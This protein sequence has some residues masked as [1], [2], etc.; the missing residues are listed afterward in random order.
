MSAS[1]D[2]S[3]EVSVDP[4]AP[5]TTVTAPADLAIASEPAAVSPAAPASTSELVAPVVAASASAQS[6]GPASYDGDAAAM[7][8]D[9]A[10]AALGRSASSTGPDPAHEPPAAS[11]PIAALLSQAVVE[12]VGTPAASTPGADVS[13]PQPT[14]VAPV[15]AR[16][17]R[18]TQGPPLTRAQ[19]LKQ[20][21][22][23]EPTDS[24]AWLALIADAEQKG[25]LERTREVYEGFFKVYPDAS[26]QWIAYADLELQHSHFA[27]VEAIFSRCLRQSTS[28][29]LWRF[30]I[31][32]AR[33]TNAIDPAD[34]E[35]AKAARTVVGKSFD[36]ALAHIGIDRDAGPIWR[37]YLAFL[38]EGVTA[39][40]WEE[41]QRM[42]ALRKTYQRAICIPLAEVEQI[43]TEYNYFEQ[44][45]NKMTVRRG[46]ASIYADR[47]Q[48]KKFLA[49][50][51]AAYSSARVAAKEMGLKLAACKTTAPLPQRVD[52]SSATDRALVKG[53]RAY[54]A[55]EESNP[56]QL[57][58]QAA[59]QHRIGFAYRKATAELRFYPEVWFLASDNARKAGKADDA[60]ALLKSG[61]TANPLRCVDD[62]RIIADRPACSSTTP[63]PSSSRARASLTTA[64]ASTASSS[65][66][67]TPS[68]T[69]A[70][71]AWRRRSPRPSS[72]CPITRRHRTGTCRRA[73]MR[74]WPTG[75]RNRRGPSRWRPCA[76]G[77]RTSTRASSTRCGT[78]RPASGSPRCAS[79][80]GPRATRRSGPSSPALARAIRIWRGRSSRPM[81]RRWATT[82]ADRRSDD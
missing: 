47:R 35:R 40:Q 79:L 45:I 26:A 21:V 13:T 19:Q 33:R 31:T 80:V 78:W 8:I 77:S 16:P 54:L 62:D 9:D 17:A 38:R 70:C 6:A 56:L 22:E 81:V 20:R 11:G 2:E 29:D 41:Q 58:D 43:W 61:M 7:A 46:L 66:A 71:P 49:E 59:L 28:V 74:R 69:R 73:A 5:A 25:D 15:A 48:A 75:L 12:D 52:W 72:S 65:T 37:D 34:P 39:G 30:Y 23:D 32:Y 53:W 36:F 68:S 82:T 51:S 27:L 55:W 44:T 60:L 4:A 67:F 63:T 57:E 76:S 42:D 10:L 1:A 14:V 50:R 24:Q 64:I 3:S 18:P